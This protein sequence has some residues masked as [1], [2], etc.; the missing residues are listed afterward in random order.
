MK[1]INHITETMLSNLSG[2]ELQK[3]AQEFL[4]KEN[5]WNKI[6][7][8]GAVEGSVQ[9]RK[10]IPDIWLETDTEIIFVSA[11]GDKA[12]GKLLKDI[13]KS[14]KA[15]SN[16]KS[17]KKK[18]CIAFLNYDPNPNEVDECKNA[19]KN[20]AEFEYLT[21]NYIA[22]KLCDEYHDLRLHYLGIRLNNERLSLL[23]SDTKISNLERIH[24]FID[25]IEWMNA[26]EK[27]N[28]AML[29]KE[30]LHNAVDH[31]NS[32]KFEVI[33]Y[34]NA[35]TVIDGGEKRFNLLKEGDLPTGNGG[36][37]GKTTLNIYSDLHK[38][39]EIKY[40]WHNAKE[41][42]IYTFLKREE[43]ADDIIQFN[44]NCEID[45]MGKN[46]PYQELRIPAHCKELTLRIPR[47]NLYLSSGI[48]YKN[49][50]A[51][52]LEDNRYSNYSIK[53]SLPPQQGF[54]KD[55]F[56]NLAEQYDRI[57]LSYTK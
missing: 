10:G 45:T 23:L 25:G 31:A 56:I 36:G 46:V 21:N 11:T 2:G 44:K 52:L 49:F 28:T 12:K 33:L 57:T 39:I 42:N 13:R 22:K 19:C 6:S 9:T 1:S 34:D 16:I 8:Y 14:L 54:M 43:I 55:F 32:S 20:K 40:K 4:V 37:G 30:L 24:V 38:Q 41:E 48:V 29:V 26:D 17:S 3:L 51:Q 7:H 27:V 35:L 5:N 15:F 53:I 18:R 47:A 50:I